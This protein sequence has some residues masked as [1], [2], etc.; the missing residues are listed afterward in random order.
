[1]LY[2]KA[3]R[4]PPHVSEVLSLHALGG[5]LPDEKADS[6]LFEELISYFRYVSEACLEEK[7]YLLLALWILYS[8]LVEEVQAELIISHIGRESEREESHSGK[9]LMLFESRGVS[10]GLR[11]MER[12][13]SN[14]MKSEECLELRRKLTVFQAR[15]SQVQ[16]PGI[17][18]AVPGNLGDV[19]RA[20]QQVVRLVD[21][22]R[23]ETLMEVIR[24]SKPAPNTIYP[25]TFEEK[26]L[27]T[28][29]ELADNSQI[30]TIAI[31]SIAAALTGDG[32]ERPSLS[33]CQRVGRILSRQGFEKVRSGANGSTEII[34]DKFLIE[35][36]RAE[37][38]M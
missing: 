2:S 37:P 8:Y 5:S 26:V 33:L 18:K 35:K 7:H 12:V 22:K 10:L 32:N 17:D 14:D 6:A 9:G 31:K 11:E 16:L 15:H 25:K 20:L 36:L 1:M 38:L 21:P 27:R 24:S 4:Q 13:Q 3:K 34:I 29:F 28:V 23:E 19:F 30:G